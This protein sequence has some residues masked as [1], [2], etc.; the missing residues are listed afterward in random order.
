MPPDVSGQAKE[1]VSEIRNPLSEQSSYPQVRV[2]LEKEH[3][4]ITVT[5]AQPSLESP[6][7]TCLGAR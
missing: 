2:A 4:R 1:T 5:G 3:L 6:G 7:P